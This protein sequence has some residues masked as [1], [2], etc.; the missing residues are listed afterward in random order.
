[1]AIVGGETREVNLALGRSF[2]YTHRIGH[3]RGRQNLTVRGVNINEIVDTWHI[4]KIKMDVEGSEVEILEA[5]NYEPI[6]EIILEYHF[7]LIPDPDWSKLR[8]LLKRL[9]AEGFTIRRCPQ[10]LT[11]PTKRWTAIVWASR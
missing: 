4:T 1:M 2:D 8:L 11:I 6:Q 3:I 7:T 10:D 5:L 9:E